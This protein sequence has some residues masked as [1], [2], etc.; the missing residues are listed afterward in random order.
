[1]TMTVDKDQVTRV[2]FA[3]LWNLPTPKTFSLIFVYSVK[4]RFK[5]ITMKCLVQV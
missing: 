3:E 5:L 1:M 4:K 2:T